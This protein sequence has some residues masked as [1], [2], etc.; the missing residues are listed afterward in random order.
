MN[1]LFDHYT[2]KTKLIVYWL[3]IIIAFS[4]TIFLLKDISAYLFIVIL[5]YFILSG[6]IS[7]IGYFIV[8]WI[9][10]N[11]F[12]YGLGY[13]SLDTISL[14]TKLI[15]IIILFY[16]LFD[17]QLVQSFNK[18][19]FFLR[20]SILSIILLFHLIGSFIVNRF[21]GLRIIDYY[22][23][24]FLFLFFYVIIID[25][26]YLENLLYLLLVIS[27]LQIP[28]AILQSR[29]IIPPASIAGTSGQE[30]WAARL[31]DAASGTF[32]PAASASLSWFLSFVFMC[33]FAIGLYKKSNII[34][35]FSLYF[36]IQY[37]VIDSKTTL[38]MTL[39]L[40]I[41]Y[42]IYTRYSKTKL[43]TDR[44][45]VLNAAL[46]LLAFS[47]LFAL[48]W[49]L[50]YKNLSNEKGFRNRNVNRVGLSYMTAFERLSSSLS[51][52]GKITGYKY[53]YDVLQREDPIKVFIGCGIN[54]YNFSKSGRA[55]K[56]QSKLNPILRFNNALNT[57]SAWITY[58]AETGIIGLF[59]ILFLHFELFR[60]YYINKFDSFLAESV[61]QIIVPF[62]ILTVFYGFIYLEHTHN[63]FV[64]KTIWILTALIIKTEKKPLN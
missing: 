9:F 18:S 36:L 23:F 35:I 16:F 7:Y 50:Y 6:K 43:K 11:R 40:I 8:L 52:Y 4:L 45:F 33:F 38:F 39:L 64:M 13:L 55:L 19:N 17:K 62:I 44:H 1:E 63:S 57:R 61:R 24:Y 41:A 20:I 2:I 48:S 46:I 59:L 29:F 56:V 15:Y 10:L 51:N 42:F 28:I 25:E 3:L 58:F 31:D 21:N 5:L 14:T 60:F 34:L 26:D 12:F 37:A 47:I 54:E 22:D 53:V 27:V 49:T 30:V 32:G